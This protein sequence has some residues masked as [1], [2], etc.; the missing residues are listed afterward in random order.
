MQV[1]F[2]T[3]VD[4]GKRALIDSDTHPRRLNTDFGL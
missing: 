1:V 3:T 4:G 2:V